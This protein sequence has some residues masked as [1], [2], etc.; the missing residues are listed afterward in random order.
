MESDYYTILPLK[1]Y[2]MAILTGIYIDYNS[3]RI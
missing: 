1:K 3:I 2:F